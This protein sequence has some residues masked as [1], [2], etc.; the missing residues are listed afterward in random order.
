MIPVSLLLV[1]RTGISR[2]PCMH[3]LRDIG[4]LRVAPK[5]GTKQI[6]QCR[7]PSPRRVLSATAEGPSAVAP[8]MSPCR[9]TS[10]L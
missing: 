6:L 5:G 4:A 10:A 3:T 2:G 8:Q 9:L 7:R 1:Q